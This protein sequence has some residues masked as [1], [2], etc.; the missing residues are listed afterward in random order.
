MVTGR[1]TDAG[2]VHVPVTLSTVTHTWGL[3]RDT[4]LNIQPSPAVATP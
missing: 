2:G 4:A 1:E 3:I